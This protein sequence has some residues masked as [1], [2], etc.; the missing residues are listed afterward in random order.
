MIPFNCLQVNLSP[1]S[2]DPLDIVDSPDPDDTFDGAEA[3]SDVEISGPRGYNSRNNKSLMSSSVT[4]EP[5]QS[6]FIE[7]SGRSCP[8]HKPLATLLTRGAAQLR[9]LRIQSAYWIENFR[10][11]QW[12]PEFPRLEDFSIAYAYFPEG[13]EEAHKQIIRWMLKNAPN[14]KRIHAESLDLLRIVPEEMLSHVE[15]QDSIDT[16]LNKRQDIEVLGKISQVRP[17]LRHIRVLEPRS[18]ILRDLSSG[19]AVDAELRQNFYLQLERILRNHHQSLE[20]IELIG[21]FPLSRLSHPPLSNLTKLSISKWFEGTHLGRLWE[22]IVS[23][24]FER[25]MPKLWEV[26]INI[27]GA[28]NGD[29]GFYNVWPIA[30]SSQGLYVSTSVRKLTLDLQIRQINLRPFQALFPTLSAL[31]LHLTGCSSG[32]LD[33]TWDF[34]PV[35]EIWECWPQLEELKFFGTKN[36]L[37]RNYDNDFCGICE[38]EAEMLKR[39]GKKFLQ[40]FHIVPIKSCLL[41]MPRKFFLKSI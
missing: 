26:E 14:L 27:T 20:I 6:K 30:N 38:E 35:E 36:L 12:H 16:C 3:R 7:I 4:G 5:F 1:C 18:R 34:A 32:H 2:L 17:R 37:N 28:G 10:T 23:I 9:S 8:Y 33:S 39:K 11:K 25:T 24:D 21:C 22:V 40:S 19:E 29:Q 31:H 13:S 15:L 41:T